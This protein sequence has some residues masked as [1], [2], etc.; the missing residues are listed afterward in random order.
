MKNLIQYLKLWQKKRS[1]LRIDEDADKNWLEM[2]VLLDKHMP[3]NDDDTDGSSGKRG[4]NLLTMMLVTLSAAAAIYVTARVVRTQIQAAKQHKN[5]IHHKRHHGANKGTDSLSVADS[6]QQ[7][8]DSVIIAEQLSAN[9]NKHADSTSNPISNKLKSAADSI[10]EKTTSAPI[11]GSAPAKLKSLDKNNVAANGN[12]TPPGNTSPSGNKVS[13]ANHVNNGARKAANN[14]SKNNVPSNKNNI[15]SGN[16]STSGD[17]Q[18]SVDNNADASTNGASDKNHGAH[19][20]RNDKSNA[21]SNNGTSA[22]DDEG[23]KDSNRL[24]FL[25]QPRHSF[26]PTPRNITPYPIPNNYGMHQT[27]TITAGKAPK[28]KTRNPGN[29][30]FDWGILIGANSSGSFTAKNL[31]SNFYGSLPVDIF[32]G[33]YVTYNVNPKWGIGTQIMVLS[34]TVAKGGTYTRPYL[35]YTDSITTLK[36]K[37][38]SDSKKIY[39]VQLPIY[40]VYHFNKNI[41]FKTGAVISFPVKQFN[42][43]TQVDSVSRVILTTSRYDQKTDFSA[44]GGVSYRYKMIV[45]EASYL[46]GLKSHTIAVSDSLIHKATNNTFQFTI[47]LQLGGNKK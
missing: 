3:R 2:H 47:K 39:S 13:P 33:A 44:L 42:T 22:L 9:E 6:S 36:F 38:I 24:V 37:S 14:T 28:S 45:F 43:T 26:I 12:S 18:I 23:Y 41:D 8:P 25:A 40:A 19:Q 46:K 10:G 16:T 1:E 11:A 35:N 31:N 17:E 29:G 15:K 34:P 27:S 4:I 7:E 5:D 32:P 21:T 30:S 20:N